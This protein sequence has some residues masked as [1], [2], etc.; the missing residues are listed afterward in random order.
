MIMNAQG[1]SDNQVLD[2]TVEDVIHIFEEW[3]LIKRGGTEN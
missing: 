3:Y 1:I 2:W